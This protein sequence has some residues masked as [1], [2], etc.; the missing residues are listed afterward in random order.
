M[1]SQQLITLFH[2]MATRM[3]EHE[4]VR[5]FE[6]MAVATRRAFCQANRIRKQSQ[7]V[8]KLRERRAEANL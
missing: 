8:H 7:F 4:A 6:Q 5:G 2:T 1:N 3:E